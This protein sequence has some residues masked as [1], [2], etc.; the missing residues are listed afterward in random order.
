MRSES[1]RSRGNSSGRTRGRCRPKARSHFRF[2]LPAEALVTLQ[3]FDVTGRLVAE[4]VNGVSKAGYADLRWQ[5]SDQRA[6][7]YFY[8]FSAGQATKK[9]RIVL[10]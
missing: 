5:A 6:G 10:R 7:V 9:G 2:G 4:P 8:R 1:F 3:I